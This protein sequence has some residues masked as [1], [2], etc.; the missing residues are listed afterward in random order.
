MEWEG[1]G[2]NWDKRKGCWG[3]VSLNKEREW[4]ERWSWGGELT[5]CMLVGYQCGEG[6]GDHPSQ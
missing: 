3:D 5:T 2:A 6:K 1:K 4:N